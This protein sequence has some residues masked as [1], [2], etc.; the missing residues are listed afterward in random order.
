[1]FGRWINCV[2]SIIILLL[3]I[4]TNVYG[5]ICSNYQRLCTDNH[6]TWCC[7]QNEFCGNYSMQCSSDQIIE[8]SIS[9]SS[10]N[11]SPAIISIIIV[12]SIICLIIC[13]CCC[14]SLNQQQQQRPHLS[15][16]TPIIQRRVY[17]YQQGPPRNV[18]IPRGYDRNNPLSCPRSPD[19][20]DEPPPSYEAAIANSS[21][22]YRSTSS[23]SQPVTTSVEL[24]N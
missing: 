5:M 14:F 17:P 16:R 9:A 7:R 13:V 12:F 20:Y 21:S 24:T 1:M 8:K 10:S 6:Y 22:K 11:L 18:H 3:F 19:L 15:I 4:S 23:S 2:L